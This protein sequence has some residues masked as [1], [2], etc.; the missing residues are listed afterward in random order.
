MIVSGI[1]LIR[2]HQ[3]LPF[4]NPCVATIGNFDGLH[5][6]HQAII[7]QVVTKAQELSLIPTV[8]TFEPLPQSVLRPTSSFVRLMRFSQKLKVLAAMGIQQVICL[9]FN[10]NLAALTPFEFIES[11]LV[12]QFGV[13]CLM[14]GEDFRFGHQ[15]SGD[16]PMLLKLA[17]Q[18]SFSVEPI[19]HIQDKENKV[20]STLIR[21]ALLNGDCSVVRRM[22]G[23]NFSVTSRVVK[24]A[25]KGRMLGF[26]TAN[27]PI[28]K[29][30]AIP[31]GVFVTKVHIADN[32][33]LG[34]TNVGTRPTFD[35]KHH[36]IE[37]HI[38]NYEGDLYGKR[39]TVEFLHKLRDE[40]RFADI[41]QLKQQINNDIL[42]TRQFFEG[43]PS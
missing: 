28:D 10:A 29:K 18:F 42:A 8:I 7:Q 1:K 23:R 14:I 38:L 24:G 6:G 11:Y 5:L 4:C 41:E 3:S 13:R 34:A 43:Y 17:K 25:K 12:K 36:V 19:S 32:S 30:S 39:I 40:M 20:S 33:Y 21:A 26:P 15:Q 22:L 27:L 35:G 37:T 16:V 31:K 2:H 9:R